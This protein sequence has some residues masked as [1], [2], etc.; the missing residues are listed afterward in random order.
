MTINTKQINFEASSDIRAL[1]IQGAYFTVSFDPAKANAAGIAKLLAKTQQAIRSNKT[2]LA[3]DE[4]LLGFRD[5]HAKVGVSNRKHIASPENLLGLIQDGRD[6]SSINPIV[7]A[8]NIVSLETKLALG[9][10]DTSQITGPIAFRLTNGHEDF[11]PLGSDEKKVIGKGEYAYIDEGRNEVICRLETR[12]GA[13]TKVTKD[14]S[15]CFFIVQGNQATD[16]AYIEKAIAR[17]QD[18]L[19]R[20]CG[21][22][23]IKNISWLTQ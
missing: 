21:A 2:D 23:E 17:L 3:S 1:G 7:D 20:Y 4:I 22:E 6:L 18:L 15:E 13:R 12:Q 19:T 16:K 11:T 9:A 14:S 8:Y 10:H 5:L